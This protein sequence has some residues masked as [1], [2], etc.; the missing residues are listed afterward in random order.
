MLVFIFGLRNYLSHSAQEMHKID[1]SK[2]GTNITSHHVHTKVYIEVVPT[3][4][5]PDYLP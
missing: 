1:N 5:M 4:K 3:L 2:V